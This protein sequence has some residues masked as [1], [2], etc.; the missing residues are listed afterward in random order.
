MTAFL[1]FAQPD[2]D[3]GVAYWSAVTGYAVSP[4]RGADGEFATLVPP[5]GDDY[6]RVQRLGEG[7]SRIHLDLHV[8]D[9]AAGAEAAM[10]LG[11]Q[12]V[13]R[14][15]GGYVVLRSP[16]GFTFCLVR[17]P[18]SVIPPARSWPGVMRSRVYQTCLDIPA[19][20]YAR[21]RDFWETIL[22]GTAEVLQ[23]RP[24]FARVRGSS[25]LALGLL[26]QRLDE[27]TGPIRA[28]LDLGTTDRRAEV[29]RHCALGGEVVA[30]EEF[31]TVLRDPAGSAYCVTDRDPATGRLA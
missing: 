27:A 10:A 20:I 9:A 2:F 3:R 7:A 22:G 4:R 24:E 12:V 26:L 30:E 11:A 31:W 19:A 28:H 13:A 1:D 6:L 5:K 17:Q 15:D 25:R 18:A 8:E 23:R 14:P 29:A 16:G 21:E